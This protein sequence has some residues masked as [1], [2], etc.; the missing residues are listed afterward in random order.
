MSIRSAAAAAVS[1]VLAI[2]LA[3]CAASVD[4]APVVFVSAPGADI[5]LTQ[6]AE[7]ALA[8]RYTRSLPQGSKWR[9]TGTVPQ[10]SVYRPIDTVFTIEGRNVHEAYLVISAQRQLVGFYLPGESR[11][12]PLLAPIPLSY[13]ELP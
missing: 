6:A 4:S 2:T 3:G 13:K 11:L 10:G 12:S 9:K 8:T 5:T 1:M 7:V